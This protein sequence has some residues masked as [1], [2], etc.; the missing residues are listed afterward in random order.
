MQNSRGYVNSSHIN[1]HSSNR[2]QYQYPVHSFDQV[3]ADSFAVYSPNYDLSG[4]EN[5]AM[6]SS[7]SGEYSGNLVE[8]SRASHFP[9]TNPF[10]VNDSS[11]GNEGLP[12]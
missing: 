11:Q 8:V 2:G 9:T 10:H 4:A 7:N 6:Y 5:F 12:K 3:A 1:E